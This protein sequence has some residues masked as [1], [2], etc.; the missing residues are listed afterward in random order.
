MLPFK[1]QMD[2]EAILAIFRLGIHSAHKS[3]TEYWRRG[4]ALHLALF[5]VIK[6]T[7]QVIFDQ[8]ECRW[9]TATGPFNTQD[10]TRKDKAGET[11]CGCFVIGGWSLKPKDYG[12][13]K[14]RDK[15]ELVNVSE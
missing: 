11:E 7:A 10:F 13:E 5:V 1:Y 9:T 3:P 12:L 6:P 15:I 4:S 2:I 8:K 14:N